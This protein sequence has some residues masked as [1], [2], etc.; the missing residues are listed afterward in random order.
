ML[1]RIFAVSIP[2]WV[3]FNLNCCSGCI[4]PWTIPWL[5]RSPSFPLRHHKPTSSP[6]FNQN[7]SKKGLSIH[8]SSLVS[9]YFWWISHFFPSFSIPFSIP[10]G[11]CP[12]PGGPLR[13]RPQD[14]VVYSRPGC[15][16]CAKA[17]ALLRRRQVNFGV[18]DVGAEWLGAKEGGVIW[19]YN[20]GPSRYKLVY[21]PY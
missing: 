7:I 1:L 3:W 17:K 12:H 4:P 16:Y 13:L 14:V 18:V 15:G 21:K 11:F 10:W 9:R 19:W 2:A 20:V 6:T 8:I 5:S